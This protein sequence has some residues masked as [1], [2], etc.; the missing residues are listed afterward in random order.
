MLKY[1]FDKRTVYNLKAGTS[2]GLELLRVN[3]LV[4]EEFISVGIGKII[5]DT[6]A[7]SH[8][9]F[10]LVWKAIPES[11]RHLLRGLQLSLF[12]FEAVADCLKSD[13]PSTQSHT[14]SF[15]H[16]SELRL[17][18]DGGSWYNLAKGS[19]MDS[20]QYDLYDDDDDHDDDDDDDEEEKEDY[21]EN[22]HRLPTWS[23]EKEKEGEREVMWDERLTDEQRQL[24]YEDELP[25]F[26]VHDYP[27]HAI[28][29]LQA[30][31][32]GQIP[33]CTVLFQNL[34]Y[35][36][37][38]IMAGFEEAYEKDRI[39]AEQRGVLMAAEWEPIDPD[40]PEDSEYNGSITFER[41]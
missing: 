40:F 11:I 1:G 32:R 41:L 3:K 33:K 16:I 6:T 20:P 34:E 9:F 21:Y 27:K 22:F 12:D 38:R 17:V 13:Y 29:L 8:Y 5:L 39:S 37:R 4:R 35:L 25:S 2:L 10:P 31:G 15:T 28:S 30:V 7:I 36:Q 14:T 18:I 23:E 19:F 26:L 24:C